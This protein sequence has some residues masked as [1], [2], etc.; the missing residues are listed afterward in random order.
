MEIKNQFVIYIGIGVCVVLVA[1]LF[2][3]SHKERDFKKGRKVVGSALTD[4]DPVFRK[5]L[6]LY[7]ILSALTMVS[8]MIAII[9]SVILM[10]R[11][12]RVE[13][14]NQTQY[15]RDIILCMD[16][17]SSV[18]EV[19]TKLTKQLSGLVKT[20]SG[21]RFGIVIFNTSP[22]LL[23]PL[24]DDYKYVSDQLDYISDCVD[25]RIKY[26]LF[27]SL[28]DE[29]LYKMEFI[30]AGTLVGADERGSSLI[31]DGLAAAAYNFTKDDPTRTKLIIF[32]T[33]N[34]LAG[35]PH[36]SVAEAAAICKKKGI[37]VYG[38]GTDIMTDA[39]HS[40]LENAVLSTGGK[41]YIGENKSSI[42][43]IV[44]DIEKESKSIIKADPLIKE[45]YVVAAPFIFFLLAVASSIIL[46]KITGR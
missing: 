24:T 39:N 38:I 19:N 3:K 16:V 41:F 23:V 13:L 27:S 36:V 10:A 42:A 4:E 1:L 7:R 11:P 25:S 20:L 21:E 2:F 12:Y 29:A 44:E 8:L 32:V 6:L 15:N 34:D 46:T 26:L 17:S 43:N 45:N 28:S 40:E 14:V 18:D 33:D 9:W 37:K 35:E 22:V 30:E 31:G 5:K